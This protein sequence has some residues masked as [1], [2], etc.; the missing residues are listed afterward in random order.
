[1]RSLPVQPGVASHG[2]LPPHLK[3]IVAGS[4]SSLGTGGRAALTTLLHKYIMS[5]RLLGIRLPVVLRWSGMKL[6]L[7]VPRRSVT[8][9]PSCTGRALDRTRVCPGHVRRW[10]ESSDSLWASPVVLVTKKD[11]STHLCVDYHWL[12]ARLRTYPYPIPHI[13]DAL[14]V[15]G[16][17]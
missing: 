6:K 9:P 4:H 1:M 17:Q 8:G 16:C 10:T 3:E 13:D 12:N 14:Q 7:T 11:G 15:L 5:S 2:P